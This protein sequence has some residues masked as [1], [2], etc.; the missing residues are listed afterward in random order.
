MGFRIVRELKIILKISECLLKTHV[1]IDKGSFM[2]RLEV[3]N[4]G[5]Q[6]L[7]Y[8]SFSNIKMLPSERAC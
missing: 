3:S 8:F 7:T 4:L 2:E 1:P 5:Q 6:K